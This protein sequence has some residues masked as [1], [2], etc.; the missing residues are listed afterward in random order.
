MITGN[1][2]KVDKTCFEDE[3]VRSNIFTSRDALIVELKLSEEGKK[4]FK[5]NDDTTSPPY[6]Y[7]K[8]VSD[9]QEV[10]FYEETLNI[11][12][13]GDD[14]DDGLSRLLKFTLEYVGI[15]TLQVNV[16]GSDLVDRDLLVFST[17]EY[18][19]YIKARALGFKVGEKAN[20]DTPWKYGFTNDTKIE[21]IR[22]SLKKK[23]RKESLRLD[24]FTGQPKVVS[25]MDPQHDI[26][27]QCFK[28]DED[29]AQRE[30][31]QKTSLSDVLMYFSDLRVD[32]HLTTETVTETTDAYFRSEVAEIV[33]HEAVHKLV[34][35]SVACHKN[36]VYQKW[37]G[38][39]VLLGFDAGNFPPRSESSEQSI[40]SHVIVS[41]FDWG[42]SKILSKEKYDGLSSSEK[43]DLKDYWS[44]YMNGIYNLSFQAAKRYHNQ[45]SNVGTWNTLTIHVIDYDSHSDDDFIGE[46]KI[47]LPKPPTN[48]SGDRC[49]DLSGEYALRNKGKE[50]KKISVGETPH[51]G[52]IELDISWWDAPDES[53]LKGSWRITIR[54]A[55]NVPIKDL[56]TS[57]PYCLV[58]ADSK[59]PDAE[60]GYAKFEQKT[61][62]ILNNLN[63]VWNE[64]L[65]VPMIKD[66]CNLL[67]SLKELQLKADPLILKDMFSAGKNEE[68]SK[69]TWKRILSFEE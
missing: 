44:V 15:V 51:R 55:S 56:R 10:E 33:L 18:R 17:T 30:S 16:D 45:F 3:P 52:S 5:I 64:T 25:S 41:I 9:R 34:K 38:S 31:F 12:R 29:V 67:Q 43:D 22:K 68:E 19:T 2:T 7:G 20:G 36:K 62:V 69:E 60:T 27:I 53:R 59:G 61:S 66:K 57:D 4:Q 6:F 50:R 28:K 23:N 42:Q 47:P 8:E 14:D 26:V 39:S 11:K 1:D 40:R 37:L 21:D 49:D 65:E 58:I 13:N 32:E 48:R 24:H 63:P 54:K 35:L 46:V